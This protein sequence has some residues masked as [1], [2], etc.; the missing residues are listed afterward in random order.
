MQERTCALAATDGPCGKVYRKGWCRKHHARWER[1]GDPLT[2][3]KRGK[4]ALLAELRAAT[5]AT[6]DECIILTTA[7]GTARPTAQV[8]GKGMLASRAVW[9]L[10]NGDP[11]DQHVLHTCHRGEE[12]CINLRHL[13][14]GDNDRNIADMVEAGRSTRGER[15][16][17][18]KLK[19]PQVQDI[20]RRIAA[21]EPY[22]SIASRYGVS[23]ATVYQIRAGK[24]WGW[25]P[26]DQQ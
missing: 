11:G 26:D 18:H 13:Y 24:V 8:D 6:T 23:T 9:V 20:R 14:L 7:Q 2:I 15:S 19:A 17:M 12:G 1:T 10:A 4:G 16:G 21:R 3:R 5:Q 22:A 25:L